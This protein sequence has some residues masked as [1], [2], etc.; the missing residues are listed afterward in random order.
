MYRYKD[1]Q[2]QPM[3]A[4]TY[5]GDVT[6]LWGFDSDNIWMTSITD[7]D[8]NFQH[9]FYRF[10]GSNWQL[11]WTKSMPS[12]TDSVTFGAPIAVWGSRD[13]DSLWISGLC[14]GKMR[15]DGA[16]KATALYDIGQSGIQR[17]RGSARNNVFFA[18]WAG[19]I[20]HFN[21]RTLHE[22]L[23]FRDPAL[24][25]HSLAVLENDVYLV[26]YRYWGGAVFVHGRKLKLP[27]N[28]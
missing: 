1:R 3:S 6:D 17:I 2:W 27:I 12:L 19:A 21:G 10:N 13:E 16:G 20:F 24:T 26:G 11:I 28:S 25:F 22:Y 5:G 18:G 14:L 9:T 15:T 8:H 23:N 4:Q 7:V